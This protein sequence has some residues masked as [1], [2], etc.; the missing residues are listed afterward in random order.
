[1]VTVTKHD[2]PLAVETPLGDALC[3]AWH[4]YGHMTD[5]DW[6]CILKHNRTIMFFSHRLVRPAKDYTM[7][8]TSEALPF[9]PV[10]EYLNNIR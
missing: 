5:Q 10:P 1:M 9:P 2:P 8:L 6:E 3:I 7:G 4:D